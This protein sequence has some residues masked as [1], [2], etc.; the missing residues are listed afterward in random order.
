MG[1]A[2][3][4]GMASRHNA[5][6]EID[7]VPGKGTTVRLIFSLPAAQTD[8]TAEQPALELPQSMRLLLVDDDPLIIES[9]SEILRGDGHEVTCAEGGQAG[10]DAF[11]ATQQQPGRPFAA[12][13]TDLGMPYV[14][15]RRVAAAIKAISPTTP[16]I[17]LTGW[18][19]RL[20]DENDIPL[21]VDRVLTKPPRL[22]ELRAAL[23]QL[24]NT[25]KR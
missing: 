18:G 17:M 25:Q 8:S 9:L 15:G 3:V 6:L 21:H 12:V 2:M 20:S 22:R 16:V 13:I 4:Y 11:A 23:A 19:Q 7:S 14:D 10:I 24:G 1:L 5:G